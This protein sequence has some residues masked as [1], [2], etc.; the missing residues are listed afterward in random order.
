M[1]RPE[2]LGDI[3]PPEVVRAAESC[4]LI[5]D[6]TLGVLD[7]AVRDRA[8]LARDGIDTNIACNVSM[9]NLHHLAMVDR[10]AEHVTHAGDTPAHFTIE[11]TETHVIEDLTAVLEALIRLRLQGFRIAIDDYGTGA[12]TMQFLMQLPSTELKIG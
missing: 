8:A 12:A 3:A 1:D 5:D 9:H 7:I 6:L 4:A 2:T 10:I 11:V